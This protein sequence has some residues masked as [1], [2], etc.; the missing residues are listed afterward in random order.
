M[1]MRLFFTGLDPY[2]GMDYFEFRGQKAGLLDVIKLIEN[3][4][5]Y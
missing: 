3:K 5:K 1:K 4:D 2:S